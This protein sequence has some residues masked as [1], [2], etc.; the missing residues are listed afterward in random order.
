MKSGVVRRKICGVDFNCISCRF[1]RTLRRTAREN[2]AFLSAGRIPKGNRSGIV[3]WKDRLR[4]L[5]PTRRPCVHHLKER[6]TYR[7]CTHDYRC[8]DCE[9][10]QFF[11]DQYAVHAVIRP[12]DV[13]T[14]EGFKIPQGF[15]VHHGHSWMRIEEGSQVRVGVDD[16][17]SRLLG[18]LDH[19]DAPLLGKTIKQ[20]RADISGIRNNRRA[21]FL[22][23]VSGVV[24]DLNHKLREDG[25]LTN[26]APYS[27]G[28]VMRVH[29]SDLR[30][31]LK[32]LMI[33]SETQ[34]FF[35]KETDRLF[36]VMEDEIGFQATDGGNL[37]NDIFGNLPKVEWERLT[38]M[39]LHTE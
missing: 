13:L 33:G 15:Y 30:P 19:I 39:F 11:Y 29:A 23:P 34:P 25:R 2:K 18:P 7:A 35:E 12:V 22:S 8:G 38:R 32:N 36:Q 28:W 27:D 17:A 21:G 37:G 20:G 16:F 9:F 1:D 10:D 3:F 26:Q 4:E 14:I 6:I 5:P 24:T 31:E